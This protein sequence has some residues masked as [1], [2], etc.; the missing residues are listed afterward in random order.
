MRSKI[1]R[2]YYPPATKGEQPEGCGK[3]ICEYKYSENVRISAQFPI[4]YPEFSDKTKFVIN[5]EV[6]RKIFL[7]ISASDYEILGFNDKLGC[8]QVISGLLVGRRLLSLRQR[9]QPYS[10]TGHGAD[11]TAGTSQFAATQQSE[12]RGRTPRGRT[13][14]KADGHHALQRPAKERDRPARQGNSYRL[15]AGAS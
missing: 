7:G 13:D 6:V 8:P 15:L 12:Q 4:V 11:S 10:T 14:E 1:N 5:P 9:Y 2:C 3:H